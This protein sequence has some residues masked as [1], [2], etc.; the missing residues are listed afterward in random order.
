MPRFQRSQQFMHRTRAV[1]PGYYIWRLR[2]FKTEDRKSIEIRVSL[3]CYY[4]A[5]CA[6]RLKLNNLRPD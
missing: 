4:P 2:R 3:I 6:R 5:T 1:G